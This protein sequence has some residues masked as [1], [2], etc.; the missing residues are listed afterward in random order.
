MRSREPAGGELDGGKSAELS[1]RART[2][3]GPARNTRRTVCGFPQL[4]YP[5]DYPLGWADVVGGAQV[6]AGFFVF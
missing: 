5:I 6:S 1:V 4:C 2:D 3:G